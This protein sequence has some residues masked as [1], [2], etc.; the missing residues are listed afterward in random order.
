ME[1]P[2]DAIPSPR[3][4]AA[5]SPPQTPA[6]ELGKTKVDKSGHRTPHSPHRKLHRG[7][8]SPNAADASPSRSP[9][10]P[11]RSRSPALR[12]S[13]SPAASPRA[14]RTAA[15]ASGASPSPR[16]TFKK[17][18]TR[19]QRKAVSSPSSSSR[20]PTVGLS[21][22]AASSAGTSGGHPIIS[23]ADDKAAPRAKG[24]DPERILPKDATGTPVASTAAPVAAAKDTEP[25][26]RR[27]ASN[28]FAALQKRFSTATEPFRPKEASRPSAV[29]QSLGTGNPVLKYNDPIS[30]TPSAQASTATGKERVSNYGSV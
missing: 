12:G 22:T 17:A 13:G 1:Q 26:Q 15:N 10:H 7:I 11:S 5:A 3:S 14:S 20:T 2:N 24:A 29:R 23:P 28:V 30:G 4:S 16:P 18:Y 6:E 8:R 19:Q 21:G 9:R 27:N 25:V